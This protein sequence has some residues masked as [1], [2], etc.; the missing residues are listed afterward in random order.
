MSPCCEENGRN[1][2]LLRCMSLGVWILQDCRKILVPPFPQHRHHPSRPCTVVTQSVFLFARMEREG[3]FL[4]LTLKTVSIS[5][6]S[7][8]R[9]WFSFEKEILRKL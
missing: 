9:S 6:Q 8:L 2:G 3:P 7:S 1:V 5:Y 4:K